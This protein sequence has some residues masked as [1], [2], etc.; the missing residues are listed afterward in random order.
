MHHYD[1]FIHVDI[2]IIYIYIFIAKTYFKFD[3]KL[4]VTQ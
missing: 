4:T 2:S 3:I 1:G